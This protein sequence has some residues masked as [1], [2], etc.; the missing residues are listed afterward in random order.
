M[1]RNDKKSYLS[2][3]QH[4]SKEIRNLEMWQASILQSVH[5]SSVL[6][7]TKGSTK[8]QTGLPGSKVKISKLSQK[9]NRYN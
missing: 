2:V 8:V 6:L 7:M 9:R 3:R 5:E 1:A 4:I